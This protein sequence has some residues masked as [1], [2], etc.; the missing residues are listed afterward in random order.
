VPIEVVSDRLGHSSS[1]ITLETYTASVPL[2]TL[3]Q[4]SLPLG[5]AC[6]VTSR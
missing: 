1:R 5:F 3:K 6:P 2:S 4:P